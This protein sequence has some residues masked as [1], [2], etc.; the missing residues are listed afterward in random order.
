M[1]AVTS[2]IFASALCAL[3]HPAAAASLDTVALQRELDDLARPFDGRVGFCARLDAQQVCL[4]GSEAFPLQSVMKLLVGLAVMEAVDRG[5]LRL[6]EQVTLYTADL[7]MNVQPIARLIRENGGAYATTIDALM[8][9][10]V[11]D[12]DSAATD[13]LIRRLGGTGA[14]QAS[15]QRLGIKGIRF[16]RDERHL[17]T[18][19][20]G[21]TWRPDY[22]DA[23]LVEKERAA[24]SPQRRKQVFDAYLRDLR[25]TAT[26]AAMAVL[27]QT[28]GDGALLSRASTD[29]LLAT[30]AKTRTFPTR[31]KAGLTPGWEIAHKTGTGGTLDKVNAATNDVGLL[32]AP[33]GAKIAVSAFISGATRSGAEHDALIAAMAAATVKAYRP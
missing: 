27:L 23:T 25:D 19:T 11:I 21:L 12:S 15:L 29:H 14:V 13:Y 4:R 16:D 1:K 5:Q 32:T 9:G 2:L 7:S 10:A 30:L 20:Q 26:P 3:A 31:L 28:L 8:A 18:E 24:V 33:D 22:V 6:D 17:Q